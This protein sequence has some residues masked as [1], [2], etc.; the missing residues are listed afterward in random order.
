MENP[1]DEYDSY[2]SKNI[3]NN[4][5][6]FI[7]FI[8]FLLKIRLLYQFYNNVDD[9]DIFG[10]IFIYSILYYSLVT[11]KWSN[12]RLDSINVILSN[13]IDKSLDVWSVLIADIF[14][15]LVIFF[16]RRTRVL[17]KYDKIFT[18]L[19]ILIS[20]RCF[21]HIWKL[22]KIIKLR[23]N[24][25]ESQSDIFIQNKIDDALNLLKNYLLQ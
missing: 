16:T 25:T 20:M 12:V 15:L 9:D 23:F 19:T 18:I 22:Y 5:L 3:V 21:I 6:I 8:V 13:I 10:L 7:M 11:L 17:M 4:L 2:V 14:I 1:N 24:K